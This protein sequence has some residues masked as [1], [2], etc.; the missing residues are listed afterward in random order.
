MMNLIRI[1]SFKLA[2]KKISWM[3]PVII[4]VLS[5]L[6]LIVIRKFSAE[7]PQ[8]TDYLMD[9]MGLPP[10][11]NLGIVVIASGI[12]S[13]EFSKGTVKFLLIRPYTR[14]KIFLAKFIVTMI[15]AVL[16]SIFL[17]LTTLVLTNLILIPG[18]PMTFIDLYGT[19]ALTAALMNLGLNLFLILFYVAIAFLL[20][21]LTRSQ[22]LAVGF[23]VS[24]VFGSSVLNT[25][26]QLIIYKYS[27]LKWNPLNFLNIKQTIYVSYKDGLIGTINMAGDSV[28][29]YVS[30][31]QMA[32]G[33]V[34]TSAILY[35]IGQKIFQ[36]RDVTLT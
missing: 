7:I 29:L 9:M 34:I 24:F 5:A 15:Y 36:K 35:F 26:N 8:A 27:F 16:F 2:K 31:W 33:L 10:L 21:A 1:E 23:G 18:S 4:F 11:M 28:N 6:F 14:A 12:I 3:I 13:S 17:L 30:T 20:Q 32:V 19:S 22:A 25:I